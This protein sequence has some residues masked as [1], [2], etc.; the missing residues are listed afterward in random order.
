MNSGGCG[1]LSGEPLRS[2]F[3]RQSA[4]R[5]PLSGLPPVVTSSTFA[6]GYVSSNLGSPSASF[7]Y[8]A[9]TL[10]TDNILLGFP[11][12]SQF[13]LKTDVVSCILKPLNPFL[14]RFCFH[15]DLPK[16]EAAGYLSLKYQVSTSPV[17][18]QSTLCSSNSNSPVW[19]ILFKPVGELWSFFF[20]LIFLSNISSVP[21]SFQLP[22][23]A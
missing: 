16:K 9:W 18:K 10:F 20:F 3:K 21:L 22:L 15:M 11:V 8:H 17:N 2:P 4:L 6:W 13:Y 5:T 12:S 23:Q 7:G 1:S 19:I 14:G